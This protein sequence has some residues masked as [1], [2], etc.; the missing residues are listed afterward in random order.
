VTI[1]ENAMSSPIRYEVEGNRA[2]IVISRPTKL[3]AITADMMRSI[4]E[5]VRR[6]GADDDIKVIVIRSV[7][8]V[9]TAG[10]D[11]ADPDNFAG[12]EDEPVRSR[13]ASLA[14]KAAWMSDLF[15]AAKPTIIQIQGA[16]VGIGA[17]MLLVADFALVSEDAAV[18]FPEERFGSAG[19][20]WAYPFLILS[21]GIKRANEILMTGRRLDAREITD[22]GLANQ[23]I[24]RGHLETAT[25]E[26]TRALCSLPRDGI[27]ANR[28]AKRLAVG[29]LGYDNCFT[30]HAPFHG[31]A[32]RIERSADEYDFMQSVRDHGLQ[33]AVAERNSVFHGPW[34]GW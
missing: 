29:T 2:D 27:A 32:E 19:S 6:A 26:L 12:A 5:F 25:T 4:V 16:C 23:V 3:N 33:V 28:A 7:G 31:A 15:H 21:V 17:M 18:G 30:A 1:Q 34:W 13:I 22:M 8:S 20:T 14:E 24:P 11:I 9:F 10:F